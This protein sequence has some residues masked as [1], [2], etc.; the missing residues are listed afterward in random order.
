MSALQVKNSDAK[1]PPDRKI[2]VKYEELSEA[3]Q[4][5]QEKQFDSTPGDPEMAGRRSSKSE[6]V[7]QHFREGG[8]ESLANVDKQRGRRINPPASPEP[9]RAV[10]T[11]HMTSSAQIDNTDIRS[12]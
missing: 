1:S 9:N 8:N 5:T 4:Q 3:E 2:E 7:D 11:G 10:A 6:H 12:A